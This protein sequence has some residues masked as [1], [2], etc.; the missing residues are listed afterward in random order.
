M[1]TL[2][3]PLGEALPLTA[4]GFFGSRI[5]GNHM[6]LMQSEDELPL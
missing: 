1:E 2:N 3:A 6:L 4:L 5:N